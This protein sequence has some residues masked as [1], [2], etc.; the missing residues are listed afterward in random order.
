MKFLIAL[1]QSLGVIGVFGLAFCD[2]FFVLFGANDIVLIAFVAS[3]ASWGWA[4]GAA[5]MATTGSVLGTRLMYRL[6][7]RGGAEIMR[8]R[9]PERARERVLGWTRRYGALPVGVAAVMPPPCPFAPF[10]V[11]AGV[12]EVPQGRFSLSVAVGR[13]VRYG[14]EAYFA[15]LIGR[16]LLHR[17]DAVYWKAVE[18]AAI[19]VAVLLAAWLLYRLR[20]ARRHLSARGGG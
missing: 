16:N 17:L 5:V 6:G 13:G 1:A 11:A 14:V 20:Q 15:M 8:K 4:V 10:V 2:S 18:V 7:R 3:K 9:I 12:I 19:G